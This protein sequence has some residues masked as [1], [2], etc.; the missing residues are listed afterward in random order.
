MKKTRWY[1]IV[2]VSAAA[3]TFSPGILE[4]HV[5]MRAEL[6][7]FSEVDIV[8]ADEVLDLLGY[9]LE[10]IAAD[11][12]GIVGEVGEADDRRARARALV[13]CRPKETL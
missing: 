10:T 6:N 12:L 5:L 2:P 8:P 9:V 11:P 7:A 1:E 13:A 4:P 3:K